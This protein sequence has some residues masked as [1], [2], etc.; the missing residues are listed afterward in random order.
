MQMAEQGRSFWEKLLT[1]HKNPLVLLFC[2]EEEAF[3]KMALDALPS[4]CQYREKNEVVI[5]SPYQEV[6]SLV[7]DWVDSEGTTKQKQE[8]LNICVEK[9]QQENMT[10]L[11]S[12]YEMY[13]FTNLLYL[14][15]L[16]K[17]YGTKL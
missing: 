4:L 16:E 8:K 7:E 12:L 3:N 11:I 9:L 14:I 1:K 10:C 15:S 6:L 13:Q 17:P 5:L 2:E